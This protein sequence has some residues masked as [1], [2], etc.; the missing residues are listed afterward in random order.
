MSKIARMMLLRCA[1][2]LI[3]VSTLPSLALSQGMQTIPTS[4]TKAVM[5]YNICRMVTNETGSSILVPLGNADEWIGGSS[6]TTHAP[7]FPGVAISRCQPQGGDDAVFCVPISNGDYIDACDGTGTTIVIQQSSFLPVGTRDAGTW[8]YA[9]QWARNNLGA[10][11]S[12][13]P[14]YVLPACYTDS[15]MTELSTSADTIG[16]IPADADFCIYYSAHMSSVENGS[17]GHDNPARYGLLHR[18]WRQY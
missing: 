12:A 10:P 18:V 5:A 15:S 2:V 13:R 14:G 6:F 3:A 17:G 4:T 8:D 16:Y 1:S 11:L 9:V 7:D